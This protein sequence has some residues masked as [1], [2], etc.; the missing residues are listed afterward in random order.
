MNVQEFQD[1]LLEGARRLIRAEED[2][3]RILASHADLDRGAPKKKTD[4]VPAATKKAEG[5]KVC[6]HGGRG[7]HAKGCAKGKRKDAEPAG[8]AEMKRFQCDACLSKFDADPT[9][10]VRCDN[11]KCGSKE[12]WPAAE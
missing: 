4:H 5:C 6:E 9:G 8:E 12:V 10:D 11:P 2:I 3:A 1:Q 7:R